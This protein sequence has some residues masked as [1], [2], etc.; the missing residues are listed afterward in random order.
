MSLLWFCCLSLK[1]GAAVLYTDIPDQGLFGV[2]GDVF[3]GVDFN[4]D[5]TTDVIFRSNFSPGS[6]FVVLPQDDHK[7]FS[8]PIPNPPDINTFAID[9]NNGAEIGSSVLGNELILLGQRFAITGREIGQ[10][11]LG[12]VVFSELVCLGQFDT[13]EAQSGGDPTDFVGIEL[14]FDGNTHFGYV[15]ILSS[16]FNGGTVVSFAYETEPNTPILAGA[17][18]EPSSLLLAS[19]GLLTRLRRKR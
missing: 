5:N 12:C 13:F 2:M 18:P 1:A 16:G 15:E 14:E 11:L 10:G 6:G 17:I 9:F 3:L 7:V 4:R 8:T 19:L